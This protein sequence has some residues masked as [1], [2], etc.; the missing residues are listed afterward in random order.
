MFVRAVADP[1][2]ARE[3]AAAVRASVTTPSPENLPSPA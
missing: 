1:S 2:L 3:I